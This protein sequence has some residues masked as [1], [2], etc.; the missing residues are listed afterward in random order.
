MLPVSRH[1]KSIVP[2]PGSAAGGAIAGARGEDDEGIVE[3]PLTDSE[4]SLRDLKSRLVLM[5]KPVGKGL[6]RAL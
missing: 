2:L 4:R 1:A 3:V 6:S 5:N